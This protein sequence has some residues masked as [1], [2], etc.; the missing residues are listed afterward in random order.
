[1]FQTICVLGHEEKA[2]RKTEENFC[3]LEAFSLMREKD[4]TQVKILGPPD[5][6]VAMREGVLGCRVARVS[7]GLR[8]KAIV[9]GGEHA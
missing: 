8:K 3:P 1:M 5:G 2:V 4:D 7:V 6:E 9:E